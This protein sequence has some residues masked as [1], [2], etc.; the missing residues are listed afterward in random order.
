MNYKCYLF[1]IYKDG[2]IKHSKKHINICLIYSASKIN[3]IPYVIFF[4][5]SISY[6]QSEA[7]N[8]HTQ[9]W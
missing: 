9:S 3:I 7:H 2:Y 6:A 1:G 5:R 4:F 8:H